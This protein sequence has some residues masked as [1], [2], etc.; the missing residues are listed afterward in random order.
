[1][2]EEKYF[3]AYLL[4]IFLLIKLSQHLATT[5]TALVLSNHGSYSVAEMCRNVDVDD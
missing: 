4:R 5:G 1:M 2:N 3:L